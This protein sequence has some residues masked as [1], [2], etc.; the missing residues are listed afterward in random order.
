ML[1]LYTKTKNRLLFLVFYIGYN[2]S[3]SQNTDS[4][5]TVTHQT[6]DSIFSKQNSK[7]VANFEINYESKKKEKQILIQRAELAEQRLTIQEHNYQLYGLGSLTLILGLI[8]YLFYNQQKLKNLQLKKENELKDALIKIETQSRMQEQRLSI[9]RDLHDNIGAQLTF[10]ISSIDNLK[11]G[12]DIK[13]KKL[14][15]KLNN[16]SEFTSETI[17]ELRDTIWAMNKDEIAIEDLK[18]RITNYI[19]KAQNGSNNIEFEFNIE[20]SVDNKETVSSVKGMNIYRIVQEAIHN[21]FKH[22]EASKISVQIEEVKNRLI[23]QVLDNGI[24]FNIKTINRG[25]GLLNME[26]RA[27]NINAQLQVYSKKTEGT[28]ITLSI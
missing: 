9:S 28:I 1:F 27:N 19:D 22:A 15:N 20:D 11:Y 13:D 8:G 26:K 3:F 16:I 25:N 7:T 23:F 14:T 21:S 4:L 18:T 2:F 6:K 10:I 5:L 24:G 17:F 12:F